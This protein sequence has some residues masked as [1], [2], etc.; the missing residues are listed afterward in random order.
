M[1][2]MKKTLQ[3]TSVL[4]LLT[5]LALLTGCL[6]N[7]FARTDAREPN[8]PETAVPVEVAPIVRGPIESVIRRS[9]HLEAESEVRVFARTANRVT[10][11][12]VEEGD[13]VEL[14]QVLLRLEDDVQTTQFER[15][16]NQLDKTQDE[17]QRSQALYD[18]QLISHQTFLD[19]QYQLR[20]HQLA[21]ADARRELDYTQVRAPIAGTVT[22]RLVKQGD[23][24]NLNQH[25]FDLVDFGSIV[26]RV[27]VPERELPRLAVGQP[28]R[29]TATSL[30]GEG[31]LGRIQ[32]IAPIVETRTGTVTVTIAFSDVTPLLPGMYVD[33]EIVTARR[34]D[35]L[36]LSR[37]SLVYDDD[38]MFVYRLQTNRTVERL[39]VRPGILD[40]DN[41]EPV[42]GFAEGDL[43]VVAGQ[44]GLRDGAKVRLPDDPDPEAKDVASEAT[45]RKPADAPEKARAADPETA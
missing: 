33:V 16:Q 38:L 9:T 34:E 35:A 2:L 14:D 32:R 4:P 11:L 21:L 36:L 27:H 40:R 43:I 12:L 37:R 15:A 23:L 17:F 18:Q 1:L 26:A 44:T 13:Q 8:S 31:R 29:V 3:W 39:V 42:T 20:Q 10:E 28:A 19:I 7:P 22:R 6:K 25:L 30:R 41:V 45:D 5:A 24:V